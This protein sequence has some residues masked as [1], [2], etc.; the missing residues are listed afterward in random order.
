LI[1]LDVAVAADG[2]VFFMVTSLAAARSRFFDAGVCMFTVTA[3]SPRLDG[4]IQ[5]S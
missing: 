2:L 1:G 5:M 3:P 4:V